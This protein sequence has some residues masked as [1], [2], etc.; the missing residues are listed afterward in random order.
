MCIRDRYEGGPN[1]TTITFTPDKSYSL[2]GSVK[3]VSTPTKKYDPLFEMEIGT[4]AGEATFTQQVKLAPSVSEARILATVEWMACDESSCLPPSDQ[5]LVIRVE[6]SNAQQGVVTPTNTGKSPS[7]NTNST[8]G[9]ATDPNFSPTEN[10]GTDAPNA[11]ISTLNTTSTT[12]NSISE[13][14]SSAATELTS[15]DSTEGSTSSSRGGSLWSAIIEAILWGFAA[16]LTPL[17]L[18]HI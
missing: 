12:E 8:T 6:N 7:G 15:T 16:L 1:A 2:V 13:T 11:A 18:I 4:F 17:S 5:E 3:Q 9:Q 10:A 14:I